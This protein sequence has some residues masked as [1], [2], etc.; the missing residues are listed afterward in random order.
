MTVELAHVE[1]GAGDGGTPLVL[2]HAFPVP[3]AVLDPVASQLADRHRVVVPDLRGFGGSPDPGDDEP[4]LDHYADDVAALLDRL[5]IDRAVVGGLS[6]GGYVTMALLRRHPGRVA[7]AVLMDTKAA[8]DTDEARANRERVAAAVLENGN[9][10]LRPMLETLLGATT[11]RERPDVV[12]RVTRWLDEARPDGV[13]WAQRA[14]A[15]RAS[16]FDTL[17]AVGVP[18]AVLVGEEDTLTGRDDAQAMAEAFVPPAPVR[19][20]AGAGHLAPVEDP[21]AVAGALHEV[22]SSTP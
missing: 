17:A 21:G 13:A 2:L 16:S 8:A 1:H 7:T 15:A 19:V 6:M 22:V 3:G 20:I 9:R 11:R 12:A 18:G 14:M 4:S 10:A 5:G